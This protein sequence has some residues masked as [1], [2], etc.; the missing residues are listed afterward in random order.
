[1][2]EVDLGRVPVLQLAAFRR[3]R[4]RCDAAGGRAVVVLLL[5]NK[6]VEWPAVRVVEGMAVDPVSRGRSA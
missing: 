4:R 2:D 1:M 5:I 3:R 6:Q